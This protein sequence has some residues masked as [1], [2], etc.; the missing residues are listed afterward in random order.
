MQKRNNF[1]NLTPVRTCTV[2]YSNYRSYKKYLREDFNKRCGYTDCSDFWFGGARNFHIDHFLPKDK[3]QHLETSYSN[4]VYSC[5]YV[6]GKKSNGMDVT[7]D[8]CDHDYNKYFFRDAYGN[9]LPVVSNIV[10]INMYEGLVL[11]L[12]RYGLV[13]QLEQ[14]KEKLS[15]LSTLINSDQFVANNPE[16]VKLLLSYHSVSEKFQEYFCYLGSEL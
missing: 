10:A 13:W 5:S 6:N 7:I 9:I 11:G 16:G 2:V 8:P 3:Y 15:E 12:R 1:R 4:L 14:L